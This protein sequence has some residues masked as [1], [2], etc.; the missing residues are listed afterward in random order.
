[1]EFTSINELLKILYTRDDYN[2]CSSFS[3]LTNVAKHLDKML[4]I[5]NHEKNYIGKI[6]IDISYLVFFLIHRSLRVDHVW[7]RRLDKPQHE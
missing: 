3:H 6:N 1:M 2:S 7:I 4:I 5:Q